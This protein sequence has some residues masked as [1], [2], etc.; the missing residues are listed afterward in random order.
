MPEPRERGVPEA[1][2]LRLPVYLRS[3]LR[4]AESHEATVS[5]ERLAE[6]AG[7]RAATVRKDLSHLGVQ[8]TPGVGYDVAHLVSKTGRQLRLR[9][10]TPILI[11]GAG[12][13]GRA[14]AKYR[15]F[16]GEGFRLV[17]LFDVAPRKVGQSVAGLVVRHV[18]EIDHVVTGADG[19]IGVIATP[20]SAA[21]DVAD[22]LIAAGVGAI[23]NFAPVSLVVA[24]EVRVRGV[25]VLVEL[26][27]LAYH[28]TF[29][30]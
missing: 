17:G 5:S 16:R 28:R 22:R 30:R 6:L 27:M 8:G 3:L 24:E 19:A 25:D 21:Q 15:G 2:V 7:I 1:A 18:S 20:T 9:P 14:L 26:Q 23:L 4:L 13:L 10:E 12:N 29:G 11:V